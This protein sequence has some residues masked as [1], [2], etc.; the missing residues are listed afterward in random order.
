MKVDEKGRRLSIKESLLIDLQYEIDNVNFSDNIEETK[1]YY[2]IT[3]K[4]E[5]WTEYDDNSLSEEQLNLLINYLQES[6]E[7]LQYCYFRIIEMVESGDYSRA[8]KLV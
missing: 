7:P 8:K 2:F 1:S 4:M 5:E 6:T 3:T